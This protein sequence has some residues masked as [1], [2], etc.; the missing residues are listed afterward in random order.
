[1]KLEISHQIF[2]KYSNVKFH[3]NPPSGAELSHADGQTGIAKLVVSFRNANAPRKPTDN[4][5]NRHSRGLPGSRVD[6]YDTESF[7]FINVWERRW[8]SSETGS[9]MNSGSFVITENVLASTSDLQYTRKWPAGALAVLK[10]DMSYFIP[11]H[12]SHILLECITENVNM[13]GSYKPCYNRHL[14][15]N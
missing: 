1:M 4:F 9:K 14:T 10:R 6:Q 7:R 3:E 15:L 5:Q 8:C 11:L 2:A 12:Y 13:S